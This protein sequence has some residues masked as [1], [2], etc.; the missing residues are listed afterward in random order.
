MKFTNIL[1]WSTVICTVFIVSPNK[2]SYCVHVH[3]CDIR[4]VLA[5]SQYKA[6]SNNVHR[7]CIV[8]TCTVLVLY[9]IDYV[10]FYTFKINA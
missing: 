1:K 10:D 7:Q 2:I 5:I 8:Y 9:M 6:L 3:V 4:F